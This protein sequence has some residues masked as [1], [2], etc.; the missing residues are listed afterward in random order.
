MFQWLGRAVR[1]ASL[2][3]AGC[4]SACYGATEKLGY[5]KRGI[6]VSRVE[7]AREAYGAADGSVASLST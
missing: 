7:G 6:L 4:Q 3:S 5:E 2:A 1:I